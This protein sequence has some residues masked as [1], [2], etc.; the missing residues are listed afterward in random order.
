MHLCSCIYFMHC[1]QKNVKIKH[2]NTNL[3]K[4]LSGNTLAWN[5]SLILTPY[6][7]HKES[8]RPEVFCKKGVLRNFT[9]F[10]GKHLCKSLFFNEVA[11]LRP[12]TLLKKALAQEISREF[13][14]ISKNTFFTEHLW[15][16]ASVTKNPVS[17]YIN[18][19]KTSLS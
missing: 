13:F 8:S 7:S 4:D 11:D 1:N 19:P 18:L 16:T 2:I 10:T 17:K 5:I 15:E 6:N 14:E 3:F 12:A 9:K